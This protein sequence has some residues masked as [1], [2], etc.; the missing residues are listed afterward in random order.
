MPLNLSISRTI[1]YVLTFSLSL[2]F[3]HC[4]EEKVEEPKKIKEGTV[5][6]LVTYPYYED[7]FMVKLL[8]D[9]MTMSFKDN[10]Y[11]NE[12]S[13]G[14][15]FTTTLISDCN[16]QTF[17]MMLDF[18]SKQMYCVLD[19]NLTDTMVAK[20]FKIPDIIKVNSFDSIAGLPTARYNAVYKG[21]EDGYDC[22]VLTTSAIEIKNYNWCNQYSALK[23]EVLLGYEVAQYGMVMRFLATKVT[24]APLP[25]DSFAVPAGFEEVTLDRMIYEMEEIFKSLIE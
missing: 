16:K 10:V 7:D 17:T 15:L 12:V 14:G 5:E 22:E 11:K 21:L 20:L 19:K 2:L 1:L 9:V 25:K 13:K 18:G 6:Y 4:G 24:E 23:D 8:P 3:I